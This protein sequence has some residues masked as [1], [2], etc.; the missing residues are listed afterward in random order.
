M[1]VFLRASSVVAC[2]ISILLLC[3]SAANAC[4]QA[5]ATGT[6]SGIVT[7]PSG[8][9][10]EEASITLADTTTKIER[11]TKT[12]D[13][14][15]YSFT[16]VPPGVYDVTLAK[17]GF[18]MVKLVKQKVTVGLVL[19]LNGTMK[20]GS[21]ADVIEVIASPGADLQTN[22]ATLG[23]TIT[24]V[25]LESLPSIGRD[26]FTFATLQ[27][28][29]TPEGSVAGANFDQNSIMLDGGNN[30]SDLDGTDNIYTPSFA[31]DPSGLVS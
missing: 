17:Q 24:G 15:Q 23:N 11:K 3:F 25:G 14:G 6:V 8:G 18:R 1:R 10:I 28:G 7:D 22:N 13:T 26:V 21:N 16:N 30:T 19:T 29:V 12:S 31:G 9:V 2:A 20:I 27:P 5:V 4:G